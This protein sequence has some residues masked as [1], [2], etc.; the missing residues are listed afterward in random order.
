MNI[1]GITAT[2]ENGNL[3]SITE[4]SDRLNIMD[5]N[6]FSSITDHLVDAVTPALDSLRS[7]VLAPEQA[8]TLSDIGNTKSIKEQR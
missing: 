8:I 5:P 6:S 3:T 2:L 7:T 1:S 4:M